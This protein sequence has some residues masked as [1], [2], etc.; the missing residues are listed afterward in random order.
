MSYPCCQQYPPPFTI[1][2]HRAP[3]LVVPL[4]WL[5][6]ELLTRF[7]AVFESVTAFNSELADVQTPH[8]PPFL[9]QYP[10]YLQFLH[11]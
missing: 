1:R 6:T 4:H 7:L 8:V 3:F 2:L 11:A 10:Q 9:L 5:L